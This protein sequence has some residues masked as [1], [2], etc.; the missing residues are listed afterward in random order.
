MNSSNKREQ[1]CA[2]VTP[3]WSDGKPS[4]LRYLESALQ[5][6]AEQTD[7][8][9]IA[10]VVDDASS[11]RSDRAT[12]KAWASQRAQLR[13]VWA[14]EN[15]GPGRCRN[16]GVQEAARMNCAFVCFLDADDISHP[17][18]AAEARRVFGEDPTIQVVYSGLSVIDEK[19]DPLEREKLLRG[20]QIILE[21]LEKS[22]L[23][24][25]DIWMD[26]ATERDT[27]T[28][29]SALN[30]RTKLALRVP[31]PE[32]VRFHEDTHTWLRYSAFGARIKFNPR[33]PSQYRIPQNTI[34]SESRD[35]AGGVDS[36]NR[37]RAQVI[38]QGLDEA[39]EMGLR[40]GVIDHIEAEKIRIGY[41]LNVAAILRAEK[42]DV[43][44]AELVAQADALTKNAVLE[45]GALQWRE[46]GGPRTFSDEIKKSYGA[47]AG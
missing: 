17:E 19:G 24:G 33:T 27:L 10:I 3:F 23:E 31:F 7:E 20:I 14:R 15:R 12:L 11:S 4:R 21:D 28:V 30:V 39:I 41:L 42:S 45:F 16:L 44:A 47:N 2:F 35:R 32:N 38:M 37:L 1:P 22:P 34:G 29:P 8:N 6:V 5:S 18:R 9:C 43:V 25:D 40:R 46:R 13:V 36:F 26:L